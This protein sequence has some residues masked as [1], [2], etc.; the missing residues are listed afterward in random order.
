LLQ[1]ASVFSTPRLRPA[2]F[3]IRDGERIFEFARKALVRQDLHPGWPTTS[4][5]A[6]SRTATNWRRFGVYRGSSRSPKYAGVGEVNIVPAEPTKHL[7]YETSH[8]PSLADLVGYECAK[9]IIDF[10][11]IAN[12]YYPTPEML[13]DLRE[14]FTNLIRSYPSSNPITSQRNLASVL[15]VNADHLII[16][17]GA[18]ELIVLINTTLIERIAVPVPTF[19]EHIEK[20]NDQRRHDGCGTP[21]PLVERTW[22]V[23]AGLF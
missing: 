9:D 21:D 10:C 22:H 12:L 16:G 20:L 2:P 7:F 11:F 1:Q 19:G 15:N 3:R 4:D 13:E 14:N 6:K 23:R 8:S 18:T 17:N 5:C